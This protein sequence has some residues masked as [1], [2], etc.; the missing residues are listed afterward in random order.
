M[1]ISFPNSYSQDLNLTKNNNSSFLFSKYELLDVEKKGEKIKR[2]LYENDDSLI[3]SFENGKYISLKNN[4][5]NCYTVC[6]DTIINQI[7]WKDSIDIVNF[8]ISIDTLLCID[9]KKITNEMDKEGNTIT[10]QDGVEFKISF[11][12]D[13]KTL[14]LYSYSPETYTENKFPFAKDRKKFLYS[15]LNLDKYFYDK[16]FNR[17]KSLDTIYLFIERG[18]NLQYVVDI[19]K[20]KNIRQENYFFNFNCSDGQFTNLNRFSSI[21]PINGFYKNKS[22]LKIN[23]NKIINCEYLKKFTSCDLNELINSNTKKVFI[24]DKFEIKHNKIKIKEVKG[25]TYCF[26]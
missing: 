9:P 5:I 17:L 15:W 19:N 11:Y 2:V 7:K 1:I 10:V 12:K 25:G 4:E 8:K 13:N 22:F 23:A 21:E 3:I 14:K 16:E 24:I 18:K 26:Y 20:S 6:N